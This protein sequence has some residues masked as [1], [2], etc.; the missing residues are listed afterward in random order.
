MSDTSDSTEIIPE[1]SG[2]E[3]GYTPTSPVLRLEGVSGM[4]IVIIR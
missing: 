4:L 1:T 2:C 3:S